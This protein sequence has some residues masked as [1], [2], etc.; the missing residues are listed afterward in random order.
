MLPNVVLFQGNG[1]GLWETDGTATGTFLVTNG[2]FV[3]G[4]RPGVYSLLDL[5][6]FGNQVLFG[7][8]D[9]T[10]K[11][12]L[13]TTDGTAAGTVELTGVTGAGTT[14]FVGLNPSDLTVLGA[15]VLFNGVDNTPGNVGGLWATNGTVPGTHEITGISGAASTGVDPTGMTVFGSKV[16]FN[17]V[18]STAGNVGGLWVTDGTKGGTHE[19]TGIG[20]AASTGV[21]P[22]DMTVFGSQVLFN[23][24][25]PSGRGLWVTNGTTGGT[26]EVSGTSGLDPTDM[27]V[28]GSEVLF[29]GK[30]AGGNIGLWVLNGTAAPQEL[31]GITG[32]SASLNPS[33]LTVYDGEVLFAGNWGSGAGRRELWVTDG[34]STGTQVV[35]PAASSGFSP[36]RF[37]PSNLE[38]YNGQVLFSGQNNTGLQSLWTTNGTSA[39]TKE[40][41]PISGARP[42][43]G[44]VPVDLTALRPQTS[45]GDI[46]F[47]STAGQAAIWELNGVNVLSAGGVSPNPGPSWQVIGT[48][49]FYDNG[50]SDLLWQNTNGQ[51][52]IWEI[53]GTNVI[54][55]GTVGPNPGPDWK[56][57]GTGDF[58]HDGHSDIVWQNTNGQ[59]SIWELNGTNIIGGGSVGSNPGPAWKV[60][61]TG[62]FNGDGHSDILWQNAN[63]QAAIWE[64]NGTNVIGAAPVGSNPG[65]AW[66]VVGAGDFNNDGHSD[67]LWQNASSGQLSIWEMNGTNVIGGGAVSTNPGPSWHAIG[68]GGGGA[69]DILFQNANGQTA[70]WDMSGTSIAGGGTVGGNVG[71]SWKAISLT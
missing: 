34:T 69:S 63:G 40:I 12:E 59:A 1:G 14:A 48:G 18:D 45:G 3:Y 10:S 21:D 5:T 42:A 70:I 36:I 61:G 27:T 22:T 57:V 56:V 30:D 58:N 52:A 50:L 49:D 15:E 44:L 53:D 54:G 26:H 46:V 66:K 23:G 62:D 41:T 19:I 29:A 43:Y 64:M 17:G 32:A 16:L 4:F 67:I 24:A 47:Q 33:D 35:I 39:G 28:F 55:G 71:V 38:V 13:W 51:A 20:G 9:A 31:T 60:V 25:D 37:N 65:P 7:G 8:R 68:T 6:V 2:P 11:F